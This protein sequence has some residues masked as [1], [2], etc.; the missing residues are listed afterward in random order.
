[1]SRELCRSGWRSWDVGSLRQ[2]LCANL[3]EEFQGPRDQYRQ[4]DH[5]CACVHAYTHTHTRRLCLFFSVLAI[6]LP[7]MNCGTTDTNA[8]PD[9]TRASHYSLSPS[10]LPVKGGYRPCRRKDLDQ[11]SAWL[12]SDSH[13]CSRLPSPVFHRSGRTLPDT[14]SSCSCIWIFAALGFSIRLHILIL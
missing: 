9:S 8:N 3:C 12:H 5:P 1:M 4:T 11:C 13:L 2:Q 7:H 6:G 10:F 14:R